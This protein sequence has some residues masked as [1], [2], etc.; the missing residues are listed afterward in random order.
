M[1][2]K[3][4]YYC[5]IKIQCF[6]TFLGITLFLLFFKTQTAALLACILSR[7]TLHILTQALMTPQNLF[8]ETHNGTY[9]VYIEGLELKPTMSTFLYIEIIEF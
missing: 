1:R 8:I 2:I 7:Y 5:L 4:V 6:C 9:L 3:R